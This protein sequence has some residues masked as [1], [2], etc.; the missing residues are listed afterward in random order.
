MPFGH[1]QQ[2]ASSFQSFVPAGFMANTEDSKTTRLDWRSN[3]ELLVYSFSLPRGWCVNGMANSASFY[4]DK[5]VL[6][7]RPAQSGLGQVFHV[8]PPFEE[9]MRSKFYLVVRKLQ[10][11]GYAFL[12]KRILRED[13]A[14]TFSNIVMKL[15]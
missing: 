11:R 6:C 2:L 9:V 10:E 12:E 8:P 15:C 13:M 14:Y 5:P 3:L 7:A 4:S 1:S